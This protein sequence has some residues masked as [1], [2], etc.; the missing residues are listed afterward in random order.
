VNRFILLIFFVAQV[1]LAQSAEVRI[2]RT[3]AEAVPSDD[4][5]VLASPGMPGPVP[6]EDFGSFDAVGAENYRYVAKDKKGLAQALPEGIFPNTSDVFKDPSYKYLLE[7]NELTGSHWQFVDSNTSAKN[8]Y[9]WAS[10][11]EDPGVKQFF[12]AIML[13]RAGLIE[14]AIKAFYAVVVHFPKTFSFTY[15]DTPW[16]VGPS[17]M[18][19][20]DLLVRRHPELNLK[21]IPG[22]IRMDNK[23]DTDLKN[24]VFYSDPGHLVAV[25]KK[26]KEKQIKVSKLKVLKTIGGVHS[27]LRQYENKHWGFFVNNKPYPIRAI[28][29]SATPIGVSPDR[30][31]WNVSK[32][33]QL[34]DTNKNGL[35]DGFFE[36]FVDKNGNS[37]QDSDEPTIGDA[38]LL[39]ELGVNTLRAYHH[40]YDKELFRKLFNDYGLRVLC[41]DL[42]GAYAVGSGATWAEGTNYRDPKQIETMLKS[43]QDMVE[44]FK[45]EPYVLMWVLGNEN[46]YGVANSAGKDP[47]AFFT[48][49]NQ[50]AELIHKLDPTRPVVLANGDLLS[51]DY[52]NKFAPAIDVMGANVYRGE[53]GFGRHLFIDVKEA[54]DKPVLITEYGC[55]AFAESYTQEQ[56]E[57]YQSMYLTNNWDDLEANMVGRG[58]GNALGGVLFEYLDEWW[59]A[60]SDLPEKVQKSRADWYTSH[61]ATYKN[62]QPTTQDKVP[63]FGFPFIDGWSY[64][65]W[66]GLAGQ[67]NG[68]TSPFCRV[69]RPS[70][71]ALKKFWNK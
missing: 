5:L 57:A 45:D 43:V 20:L 53:Q 21:Y 66:Y 30:G 25:K 52:I 37:I 61:S 50:A 22:H 29:Y 7:K 11:S 27:Q 46:V 64:E 28:T 10:T 55:S 15:Y 42:L 32:D 14:Q 70:Y 68:T 33:W 12:T 40:I 58:V 34:I 6:Y 13:E 48:L 44:N 60:N 16:Y 67:G 31:T 47:E 35:H 49:V 65:E 23:Y 63:Q 51:L 1:A 4:K 39:K 17:S 24:D 8:F 3:R 69:L 2:Y 62:L 36:A 26:N 19:R 41:G 59:K 18:D 71:F 38:K 54:L 9:K 56:A